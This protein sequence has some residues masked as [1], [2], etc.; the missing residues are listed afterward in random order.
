MVSVSR[1]L[2]R[3]APGATGEAAAGD[4]GRISRRDARRGSRDRLLFLT[5]SI[6]FTLNE[7]RVAMMEQAIKIAAAKTSS[8]NTALHWVTSWLVVVSSLPRS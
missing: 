7:Q 3:R 1:L 4:M 8:P 5:Q 6:A 2:R